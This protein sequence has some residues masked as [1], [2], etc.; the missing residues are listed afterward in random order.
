MTWTIDKTVEFGRYVRN[1]RNAG[2]TI[3]RFDHHTTDL[4]C[5]VVRG[6]LE[7]IDK[8]QQREARLRDVEVELAD[9]KVIIQNLEKAAIE[10]TKGK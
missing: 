3:A 9:K 5:E 10:T 8:L 7:T 6:A 4:E 1:L 2:R